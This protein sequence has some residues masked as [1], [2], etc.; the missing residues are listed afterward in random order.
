VRAWNKDARIE[1]HGETV[2]IQA[3]DIHELVTI[4]Y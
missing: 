1:A 4:E 2:E 3:N